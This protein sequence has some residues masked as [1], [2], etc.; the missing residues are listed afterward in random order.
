MA[1]FRIERD[2]VIEAPMEVVWRTI[3]E[4]DQITRWFA[5]RVDLTLEPGGCGYMGFGEHHG[6]PLVV[7]TVDR[8]N[9]FSFRWNHPADEEPG[10]ANSVL[11]EFS[12]TAQ[13]QERTHL[14]VVESGDELLAWS[15]SEKDRY[16][17]EHN[18]GWGRYL[19]RLAGLFGQRRTG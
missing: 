4:P 2:I 3:T 12:L 11:V 18:G 14:R 17:D 16:A 5:D 15:D 8:P 19:H 9:H 13:S 7:E 10:P 1:D 6:G